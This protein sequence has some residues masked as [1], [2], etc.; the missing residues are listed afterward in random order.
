M[1]RFYLW[2]II[3][4]L[5]GEITKIR[6]YSIRNAQI[7]DEINEN[8]KFRICPNSTIS[9]S[10]RR[11]DMSVMRC[12]SIEGMKSQHDAILESSGQ[13]KKS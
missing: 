11:S 12:F 9:L 8:L 13:L 2:L 4:R 5:C 3:C 6:G 1:L 7:D 10:A